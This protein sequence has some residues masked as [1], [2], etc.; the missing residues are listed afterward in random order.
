MHNVLSSNHDLSSNQAATVGRATTELNDARYK[1]HSVRTA[2]AADAAV[3]ETSLLL[4]VP[5][6]AAASGFGRGGELGG[7][8][9]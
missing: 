6:A 8:T 4:D 3:A 1:V 9:R 2:A 5:A 7:E